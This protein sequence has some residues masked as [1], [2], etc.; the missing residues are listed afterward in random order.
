MAIR[1]LLSKTGFWQQKQKG[2]SSGSTR[3]TLLSH[4]YSYSSFFW[5]KSYSEFQSVLLS[6]TA[7][8]FS[9][10]I[11]QSFSDSKSNK[12][13]RKPR[14]FC[15]SQRPWQQSHRMARGK[16]RPKKWPL[17]LAKHC[18][19]QWWASIEPVHRWFL[20]EMAS[21]R[22]LFFLNNA[23]S[24]TPEFSDHGSCSLCHSICK[25]VPDCRFPIVSTVYPCFVGIL[26]VVETVIIY[27]I[28]SNYHIYTFSDR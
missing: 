27:H 2:G 24:K 15:F 19:F 17:P 14:F 18:N 10:N 13:H 22:C 28:I 9:S 6:W 8:L 5:C 16:V 11:F 3:R 20:E 23:W 4:S 21:I 7:L 26:R 1:D 12:T 25:E